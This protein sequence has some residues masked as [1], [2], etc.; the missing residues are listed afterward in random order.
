MAPG[1][2]E[3]FFPTVEEKAVPPNVS[4]KAVT[5]LRFLLLLWLVKSEKRKYQKA[6]CGY[7]KDYQEKLTKDRK[8]HKENQTVL[9]TEV[10][11]ES[12]SYYYCFDEICFFRSEQSWYSREE[13]SSIKWESEELPASRNQLKARVYSLLLLPLLGSTKLC[14]LRP[15]SLCKP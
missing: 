1:S 2:Q 4:T 14:R 3:A 7:W 8:G 6:T 10:S 15:K 11:K 5:P 13:G 9:G 12:C